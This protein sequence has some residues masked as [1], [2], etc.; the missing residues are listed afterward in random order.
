MHSFLPSP[1]SPHS[2]SIP[3]GAASKAFRPITERSSSLKRRPSITSTGSNV[4]ATAAE[5]R[6]AV[7]SQTLEKSSVEDDGRGAEGAP[8]GGGARRR[9]AARLFEGET[10][11]GVRPDTIPAEFQQNRACSSFSQRAK[12]SAAPLGCSARFHPRGAPI[13]TVWRL[14]GD[15]SH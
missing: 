2:A 13:A 5:A 8:Q 14:L 11:T 3:P 7:F 1:S 12:V 10:P 6:G 4:E 9:A 15:R